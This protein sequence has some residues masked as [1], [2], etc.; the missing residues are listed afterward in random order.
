MNKKAGLDLSLENVI[1]LII[2]SVLILGM[3]FFVASITDLLSN[4]P[5][6]GTLNS[7]DALVITINQLVETEKVDKEDVVKG[8]RNVYIRPS[9][10]GEL[11]ADIPF[12]IQDNYGL[13]GFDSDS[14]KVEQTCGGVGFID[15]DMEKP[16]QC[17]K[18]PCLCL[19][20]LKS[21]ITSF[22]PTKLKFRSVNNYERCETLKGVRYIYTTKEDEKTLTFNLGKQHAVKGGNNYL[23]M[24]S[25]CG[26]QGSFKVR[27]I[28]ILKVIDG[29]SID[30]LFANVPETK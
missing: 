15:I 3:I 28:R 9:K 26:T 6:Q 13:I 14:D 22:N 10:G 7:F 5:E 16:A 27:N 20:K 2:G 11:F 23:A 30:I 19:A 4:R 24:W 8:V 25:E 12:F 21:A 1:G 18:V 17:L 29:D